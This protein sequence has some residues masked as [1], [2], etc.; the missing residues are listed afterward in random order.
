[1]AARKK[2]IVHSGPEIIGG[3]PAFFRPRVHVDTL[4]DW[5]EHGYTLDYYLENSRPVK[6][7]TGN[8]SPPLIRQD[9]RREGRSFLTRTFHATS[10]G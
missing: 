8:C 2:P 10:L 1:M 6:R 3:T 9:T 7:G 4:F 5:L